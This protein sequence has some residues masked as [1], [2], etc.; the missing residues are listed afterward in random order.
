MLAY[1]YKLGRPFESWDTHADPTAKPWTTTVG[2]V[3]V[4]VNGAPAPVYELIPTRVDF[5]VPMNAPQ[6]DFA[7]FQVIR[8]STGQILGVGNLP[9]NQ[10]DPGFFAV[11]GGA[12]QLAATNED[13]TINRPG[14]GAARGSIVTLYGTG[15]GFIPNAPPDGQVGNGQTTP[16]KPRVVFNG[17]TLKDEDIQYSGLTSFPAGW[18]LNIK[19]PDPQ[20]APG[21]AN[22]VGVSIYDI[23]SNRGPFG[24]IVLTVF[25]K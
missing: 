12:G 23:G 9:M 15:Q 2:D 11:A 18:Q 16:V 8:A 10:A 24:S 22:P 3:Q 20:A 1:L 17:V 14:N 21:S 13:N 19:V 25:V 7:E 6:S 4:L 5:M